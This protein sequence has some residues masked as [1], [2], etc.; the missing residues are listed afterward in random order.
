MIAGNGTE[1]QAAMKMVPKDDR[2]YLG[3]IATTGLHLEDAA[4]N[5]GFISQFSLLPRP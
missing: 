3:E 2:P 4:G 5:S 1:R